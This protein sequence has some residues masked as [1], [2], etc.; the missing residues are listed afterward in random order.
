MEYE[1]ARRLL[2]ILIE[3]ANRIAAAGFG[4]DR[5]EPTFFQIVDLMRECAELK[6]DFLSGVEQAMSHYDAGALVSSTP[7]RELIELVAHE[8]RWVEILQC[9]EYRVINRFSGDRSLAIG[10]IAMSVVDSYD[11]RW[12]D[13]EFY[14]RYKR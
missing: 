12:A 2:D 13:R 1:H 3:N 11:D 9:A 14:L 4:V 8:F 5:L 10:D 6:A 7:S